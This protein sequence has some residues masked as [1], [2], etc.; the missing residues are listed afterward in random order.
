MG[1]LRQVERTQLVEQ[2]EQL[3]RPQHPQA[4]LTMRCLCVDMLSDIHAEIHVPELSHSWKDLVNTDL[5]N[6]SGSVPMG[7]K[8]LAKP[9]QS[10][11]RADSEPIQSRFRA[12]LEPI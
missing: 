6:T 7:E 4:Q 1:G 5:T 3:R 9:I 10:R 8:P 11:F 2:L 12:D